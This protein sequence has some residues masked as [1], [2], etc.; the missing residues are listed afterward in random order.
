[1]VQWNIFPLISRRHVFFGNIPFL[2][3]DC[4]RKRMTS[5]QKKNRGHESA[6]M[7]GDLVVQKHQKSGAHHWKNS[8]QHRL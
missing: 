1:M 8:I 5:L 3:N 6:T 4:G 2:H 7:T